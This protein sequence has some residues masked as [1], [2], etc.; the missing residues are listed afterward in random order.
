[1]KNGRVV[2]GVVIVV[3]ILIAAVLLWWRGPARPSESEMIEAAL[4]GKDVSLPNGGSFR[5]NSPASDYFALQSPT[6]RQAFLDKMIDEQEAVRKKIANGEIKLPAGTLL[7]PTTLPAD[8]DVQNVKS[9]VE[10]KES[11]DGTQK[12]VTVRLNA[13]D[14]S[15][16]L[17]AQMQEFAALLRLRRI[18]RGLPVDGPMTIIRTETRTEM[19]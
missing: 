16:D 11:A 1:M 3:G 18:E 12:Q 6:D 9:G 19:R 13:D 7:G 5:M 2:G 15:P 17:R 8:V 4:S 10:V 14:L